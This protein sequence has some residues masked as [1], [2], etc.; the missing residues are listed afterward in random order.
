M[1]NLLVNIKSAFEFE[2]TAMDRTSSAFHEVRGKVE[3]GHDGSVHGDSLE[4]KT[5]G[6]GL[7]PNETLKLLMTFLK[8][9]GLEV[10]TSCGTHF[11]FS[12]AGT[13]NPALGPALG[14]K[15]R[16]GEFYRKVANNLFALCSIYEDDLFS[17]MP[18]SRQTNQ[19]CQRMS[20]VFRRNPSEKTMRQKMG[21]MSSNKHSNSKRYCWI[22]F[23]ELFRPDGIGTVEFRLLGNTK[24]PEFIAAWFLVCLTMV[25]HSMLMDIHRSV[26]SFQEAKAEIDDAVAIL[27]QVK[28]PNYPRAASIQE[29]T[30]R[31]VATLVNKIQ[32]VTF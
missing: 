22:N 15:H 28:E 3:V 32:E 21:R 23:V 29:G 18:K 24:R 1:G 9:D 13:E 5:T 10:D 31:M 25:Y 16:T 6:N 8:T 11:H 19:Y 2:A 26:N 27:E 7:N 14:Q 4:I 30:A 17:L 12:F 20:N